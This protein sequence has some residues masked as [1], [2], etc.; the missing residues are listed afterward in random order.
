ML[1]QRGGL[2]DK[3]TSIVARGRV[4]H[5]VK[6]SGRLFSR[7]R[8]RG[9]HA[10]KIREHRQSLEEIMEEYPLFQSSQHRNVKSPRKTPPTFTKGTST[11][12]L[13]FDHQHNIEYFL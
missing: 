7:G 6:R 2:V 11:K 13:R 4:E 5:T 9:R 8:G 10:E 1:K 3:K 12:L